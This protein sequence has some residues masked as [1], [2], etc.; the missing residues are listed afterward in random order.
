MNDLLFFT[1]VFLLLFVITLFVHWVEYF[2]FG[3]D[4]EQQQQDAFILADN[5]EQGGQLEDA[6]GFVRCKICARYCPQEFLGE[7]N[8]SPCLFCTSPVDALKGLG[9]Y[10]EAH[11]KSIQRQYPSVSDPFSSR[12]RP[13]QSQ[14]KFQQKSVRNEVGGFTEVPGLG[15]AFAACPLCSRKLASGPRWRCQTC[16]LAIENEDVKW[17]YRVGLYLSLGSEVCAGVLGAAADVLFGCSAACW[18]DAVAR[19]V[20]FAV[21]IAK[22][23]RSIDENKVAAYMATQLFSLVDMLASV[24]NTYAAFE[25]KFPL[26]R[27]AQQYRQMSATVSRIT[28]LYGNSMDPTIFQLWKYVVFQTLLLARRQLGPDGCDTRLENSLDALQASATALGI[29][30]ALEMSASTVEFSCICDSPASDETHLDLDDL[31]SMLGTHDIDSMWKSMALQSWADQKIDIM[32]PSVS[33]HSELSLSASN[34]DVDE[35]DGLLSQCSQ[36]LLS[37]AN[38]ADYMDA[39][40]MQFFEESIHDEQLDSL[41]ADYSQNQHGFG[42]SLFEQDHRAGSL[43]SITPSKRSIFDHT[44]PSEFLRH[45]EKTPESAA[46]YMQHN[47]SADKRGITGP[48]VL[49]PETPT[50]EAG[51]K[52]KVDDLETPF[53][54]SHDLPYMV[55]L[56]ER[57]FRWNHHPTPSRHPSKPKHQIQNSAND[58][59]R[60]RM[61]GPLPL[62][63]QSP[64]L[65]PLRNGTEKGESGKAHRQKRGAYPVV[66][67]PE[68]PVPRTRPLVLVN[69]NSNSFVETSDRD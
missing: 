28:P 49:A 2:V 30:K 35:V 36:L 45:L 63:T 52:R 67:A 55:P 68:T 9:R 58:G 48:L 42:L 25:L 33:C 18:V 17:T 40:S 29:P 12:A 22:S 54:Q 13:Q 10:D 16:S 3:R 31:Q 32:C 64:S 26:T 23:C 14:Q 43:G 59:S 50:D 41:F 44:Q 1:L 57:V 15:L 7:G 6:R 37:F 5:V 51:R 8:N 65:P 56:T 34:G 19:D 60:T 24:L 46:H 47:M 66:L 38:T 4:H 62:S 53:L 61:L 39:L 69:S 27:G 20:A 21:E 11:W